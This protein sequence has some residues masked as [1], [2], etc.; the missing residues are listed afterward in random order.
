RA[1]PR[2]THR[3]PGFPGTRRRCT[4]RWGRSRETWPIMCHTRD[5]WSWGALPSRYRGEML[6]DGISHQVPDTDPGETEEWID[7]F[8]AIVDARGRAR[9][10][11]LP[12]KLLER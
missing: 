8:D 10:R 3:D 11:Y 12:M 7:S 2:P 5:R 1:R 6:F 9:A 4:P